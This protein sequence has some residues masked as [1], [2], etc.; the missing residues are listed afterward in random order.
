MQYIPLCRTMEERRQAL[1]FT[2]SC[3]AREDPVGHMKTSAKR[4][5]R[6]QEIEQDSTMHDESP[7]LNPFYTEKQAF[8]AASKAIKLLKKEIIRTLA[9]T[10]RSVTIRQ[11][12]GNASTNSPA[13]IEMPQTS[14]PEWVSLR[15]LVCGRSERL[16][17][18]PYAVGKIV[19]ITKTM[20]KNIRSIFVFH[21]AN[22]S[23]PSAGG[24]W[25]NDLVSI[26]AYGIAPYQRMGHKFT[27]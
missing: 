15:L 27:P 12:Y 5:A 21:I 13:A 18:L 2:C 25:C 4:R 20:R 10:L 7:A 26:R 19:Q 6:L 3:M 22:R 23:T 9:L 1:W 17:I 8:R 16:N 14:V 24:R 11:R